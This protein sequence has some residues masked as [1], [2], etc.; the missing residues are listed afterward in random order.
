[1]INKGENMENILEI[2]KK[3]KKEGGKLYLVG[4]AVRDQLLG[5][6]VQ[7]KDY[8][9]TGI[10]SIKFQEL[11]PKAR[12]RGKSFEVFQLY[13]QEF[14]MART[15]KK[16]GKGHK[17]F[18]IKTGEQITIKEDLARRDITINSMAQ[19]C[20]TGEL[21]DLYGGREDLKNKTIRATTKSF[22][23]DP[24]RV[25]RVARMAAILEFDV[26]ENTIKLMNNL[27]PE[28]KTLSKER[29][30]T[31][32]K[33]ALE[34]PRPSIFFKV[35]KK[36]QV[37]DVHFKEIND[38]IG[39]LQPEKYHPEGDAFCHTMMAL[40][41]SAR[42]TEKLEI[43][44][45]SLVHDLGKGI[46]PKNQYP[47]HYGHEING[48]PLVRKFGENI[49]APN[50]WIKCGE[51][52]CREHMRGGIFNKMKPNKKIEFIERIDK[53]VL[54]LDGLQIVVISDKLRGDTDKQDIDNF[55][56]I[57]KQILSSINGKYIIDKYGMQSGVEFGR[58]LH[59][60]RVKFYNEN[61]NK[62]K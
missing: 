19:D 42:L 26:E 44:F 20:L 46:T 50:L 45:A 1:M 21:I 62:Q 60:E 22:S 32:F 24:L 59:E 17:E 13:G 29:V 10:T 34:A 33:K 56:K 28:L 49:K 25:Y 5:R 11:F 30:F 9:V 61:F 53:S 12:S 31:E 16:Q 23:E 52:A 27:K 37:L 48:V 38:L 47:H 3:I 6:P 40:D 54:G 15:E 8:C 57:G 43:R 14:A 41:T 4:G 39:A 58:K 18:E 7:D 36:A 51:V 35:L 2:A 55:E